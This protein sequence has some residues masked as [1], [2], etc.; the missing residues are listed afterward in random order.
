MEREQKGY[1]SAWLHHKGRNRHHFEYWVDYN[2]KT[3]RA[4]PVKMPDIFIYEMFCD[5]VSASKIYKKDAYTN[6]AP[7]E[8]FRRGSANRAIEKQTSQKLEMLLVML[9]EKGE[10]AVFSYIKAQPK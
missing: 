1:S 8:Y 2:P 9:A 5:R 6:D 4:E 7:L 10:E 3:K